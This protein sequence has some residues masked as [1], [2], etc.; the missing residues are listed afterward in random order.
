MSVSGLKK[1]LLASLFAVVFSFNGNYC[2]VDFSVKFQ[3]FFKPFGFNFRYL[4]GIANMIYTSR[5]LMIF[6]PIES[7]GRI[8]DQVEAVH[9]KRYENRMN[10]CHLVSKIPPKLGANNYH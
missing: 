10:P 9:I 2:G 5:N 4:M 6:A 7:P 1:I 3:N 8:I